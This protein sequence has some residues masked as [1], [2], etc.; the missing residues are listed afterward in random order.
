MIRR[1]ASFS[2]VA[3][4]PLLA[5]ADPGADYASHCAACHGADRLGGTGPALIPE[6][7]GRLKGIDQI[8]AK[9]RVATQMAG[10][11]AELPPEQI[12]ALVDYLKSPLDHVPDWTP[13]QMADL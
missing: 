3:L 1:I 11:E 5:H 8:I 2:L 12:A 7:L 4:L 10:F 9:G 6:T 13:A